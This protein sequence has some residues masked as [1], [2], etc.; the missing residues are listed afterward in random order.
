M[1]KD[2]Y[3]IT[4]ELYDYKIDLKYKISIGNAKANRSVCNCPHCGARI[5]P[6]RKM[7][8]IQGFDYFPGKFGRMCVV[9]YECDR[10]FTKSFHH[11]LKHQYEAYVK[12]M[13]NKKDLP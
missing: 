12:Y 8:I 4:T 2:L 6:F 3:R 7:E 10:C 11:A 1:E 13:E 5:Y 9:I